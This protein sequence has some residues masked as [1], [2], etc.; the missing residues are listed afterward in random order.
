MLRGI[1]KIISP[2]LLKILCEMAHEDEIAIADANYPA[3]SMGKKK[4]VICTNIPSPYRVKFFNYLIDNYPKYNITIIYSAEAENDRGWNI[5]QIEIKNSINLKSKTLKIKGKLDNKYIHIPLN[6]INELNRVNPDVIVAAEYN[7]TCVLAYLW[8]RIKKRK[9]I[10][11]SDG[12][13]S[14][15]KNINIIQKI[16]RTTFCKNA[17]ALIASSSKSKEAQLHY[18]AEEKKIFLSYLTVDINEYLNKKIKYNNKNILYV[19]NLSRRKGV[20]LLLKAM[21]NV[22]LDVVLNIVGD[23]PEK[24]NLFKLTN[25]LY[26]NNK[27][28]FLGMKSGKELLEIYKQNDIFVIPSREDCFGLVITEAMCNSLP[29]I[30][31]KYADGA[32]DLIQDHINGFIVDPYDSKLFSK[33]IMEALSDTNTVKEMGSKAFEYIKKFSFK[34]VAVKYMKAIEYCFSGNNI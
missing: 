20:D 3:E 23:G 4:V 7:P 28:N 14:T 33:V 11:W 9:F 27:V 32:Y 34:N 6:I 21:K 10:S 16:I 24:D 25:E 18:G 2:E 13:L 17:Q 1:S 5:D 12:T 15:E 30:S 31:S 26:I 22:D 19:G 8:C 29:V